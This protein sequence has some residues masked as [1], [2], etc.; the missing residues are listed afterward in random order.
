MQIYTQII[1]EHP[2]SMVIAEDI[3][4]RSS[5]MIQIFRAF[6]VDPPDRI[7]RSAFISLSRPG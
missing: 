3:P 1:H 6:P 7:R 4:K 5:A 2:G